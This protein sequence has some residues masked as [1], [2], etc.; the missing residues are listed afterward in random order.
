LLLK[1]LPATEAPSPLPTP[2]AKFTIASKKDRVKVTYRNDD[3]ED[4]TENVTVIDW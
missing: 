1:N 2:T 4:I 3:G